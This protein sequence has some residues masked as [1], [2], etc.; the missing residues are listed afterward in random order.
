MKTTMEATIRTNAV[1]IL[2]ENLESANEHLENSANDQGLEY[3]P[4][5]LKDFTESEAEN[6]PNFFRWLFDY[7]F[8]ND[9]DCDLTDEQK[10]EYQKF[11]ELI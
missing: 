3:T 8:T 11:L 5:T 10:A 9:F 7:P 1:Q 6:D 2:E 4:Y